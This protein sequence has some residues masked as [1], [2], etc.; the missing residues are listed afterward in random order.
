MR[1]FV[2]SLAFVLR[3]KETQK[4]T[5]A[6]TYGRVLH[7]HRRGHGFES[8][9]LSLNISAANYRNLQRNIY[10][11]TSYKKMLQV[12]LCLYNGL[13]LE[14]DRLNVFKSSR[15]SSQNALEQVMS[16]SFQ[17]LS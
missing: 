6:K 3:F 4:W 13:Q 11:A 15:F 8:R 14:K 17:E 12:L 2:L 1:R 10:C 7:Q 5:I 16:C 9:S